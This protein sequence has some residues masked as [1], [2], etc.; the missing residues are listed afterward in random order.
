MNTWVNSA[1]SGLGGG[2]GSEIT[3]RKNGCRFNAEKRREFLFQV[4][5]D[6]AIARGEARGGCIQSDFFQS[7]ARC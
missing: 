6:F 4:G 7:R 2:H 5:V 3:V 1:A